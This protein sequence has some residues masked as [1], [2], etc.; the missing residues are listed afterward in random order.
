MISWS[1]LRCAATASC[2]IV[3]TVSR[4]EAGSPVAAPSSVSID[5][6][7]QS[8]QDRRAAGVFPKP[9]S[10][11]AWVTVSTS[12]STRAGRPVQAESSRG[13][14]SIVAPIAA[15]SVS[16]PTPF[17]ATVGTTVAPSQAPSRAASKSAPPALASSIML[18]AT[19]TGTP[20]SAICSTR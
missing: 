16:S 8:A 18:S 20:V 6:S 19:M 9:A 3:W 2:W 15:R 12:R 4:T 11:S 10:L 17:E 13:A 5:S 7:D 1:R 14:R